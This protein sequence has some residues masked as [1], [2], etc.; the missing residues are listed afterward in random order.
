[1]KRNCKQKIIK[2]II[3]TNADYQFFFNFLVVLGTMPWGKII[4][5]NYFYLMKVLFLVAKH[6]YIAR[7]TKKNYSENI[8]TIYKPS[9]A[10]NPI[11]LNNFI[12]I[13]PLNS[14]N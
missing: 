2:R 14:G 11:L 1:M 3:V 7:I 8:W 6:N 5:A 13:M 4:A 9:S 10:I 12:N